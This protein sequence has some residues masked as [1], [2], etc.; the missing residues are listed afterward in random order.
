MLLERVSAKVILIF[1]RITLFIS[2]LFIIVGYTAPKSAFVSQAVRLSSN[3]AKSNQNN[4]MEIDNP[5]QKEKKQCIL[6]SMAIN[7]NYKNV[8]L[9]SQFQ[10]SYTG[11][12]YG[13]HITG[14]CQAKQKLVETEII[15]SQ[16]AGHMGTYLKSVEFLNDPRL[17]DPERPLRPHKY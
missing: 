13:R 3:D 17:F 7:P 10:S 11:R 9:L 2:W 14:L 4:P 12:I 1:T 8:R 15:K 5:F 16:A 6:C